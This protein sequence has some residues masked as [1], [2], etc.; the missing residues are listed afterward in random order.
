MSIEIE[1]RSLPTARQ[2]EELLQYMHSLGP[3]QKVQRIMID[4]SGNNRE[5]TVTLRSN[6]GK[7]ELVVKSG[8]LTDEI[9]QEAIL[10]LDPETSLETSLQYLALMGYTEAMVSLRTMF[11][12]ATD[13]FEFSLRDVISPDTQTVASTLLEVEARQVIPGDEDA[14]AKAVHQTM[15]EHSLEPLDKAGWEAWVHDIYEHVD[16]P[17][18]YSPD[19]AHTLAEQLASKA[20]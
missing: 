7:Q 2:R 14:A 18:H 5:R 10:T 1:S 11:I 16:R 8:T 17:F 20:R 6:N 12:V 15:K 4:F 3:V 9:R 13:Q 19:N